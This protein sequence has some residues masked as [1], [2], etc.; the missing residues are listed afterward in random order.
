MFSIRNGLSNK[1]KEIIAEDII[2]N[3]NKLRIKENLDL[4]DLLFKQKEVNESV[5]IESL[6][7]IIE[8]LKNTSESLEHKSS[9][10]SEINDMFNKGVNDLEDN[11]ST[12]SECL[13]EDIK[14]HSG[15]ILT[16]MEELK[17]DEIK[18]FDHRFEEISKH[19]EKTIENLK[20]FENKINSNKSL[21]H[22]NIED[23]KYLKCIKSDYK[24]QMTKLI[25]IKNKI[26]KININY[27]SKIEN[28]KEFINLFYDLLQSVKV[29]SIIVLT[30]RVIYGKNKFTY[31]DLGHIDELYVNKA[32][33]M[34]SIANITMSSITD[35]NNSTYIYG[36]MN[37]YLDPQY[38][39]I[40]HLI[41]D[42]N[43]D[44]GEM[45]ISYDANDIALN[46]LFVKR[47]S[48]SKTYFHNIDQ[49]IHMSYHVLEAFNKFMDE[50]SFNIENLTNLNYSV[51]ET[52][53]RNFKYLNNE[54][55]LAKT[56]IKSFEFGTELSLNDDV[57]PYEERDI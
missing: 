24:E 39:N 41:M 33:L 46:K 14:K 13:L 3:T 9:Y 4:I 28:K 32:G 20:Y 27:I 57:K 1:L 21:N 45:P 55:S 29:I 49:I 15:S 18:V 10:I 40:L 54:I 17:P 38:R 22:L 25:N 36:K 52:M 6:Y 5:L 51:L 37:K 42:L 47:M 19:F 56:D 35:E 26:K 23:E 7:N 16:E 43:K 12:I 50:L 53:S 44:V 31:G 8:S 34:D 2:V 48:L 30:I 11:F